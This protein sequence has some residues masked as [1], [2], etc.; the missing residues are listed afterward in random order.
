MYSRSLVFAQFSLIGLMVVYSQGIFSSWIGMTM[1]LAGALIGLWAIRHNRGDNFNIRPDLK[2]GCELIT[3]G[4][5]RFVRHPMY[6]SVMLMTLALAVATPI[7]LE[8]SSFLLLTLVLALKAVRE[9]RL[10]CEGS[11]AY[12]VYMRKTKRFIPFIY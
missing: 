12:K 1:L 10:W 9:E 3:T 8:W 7:Y 6:T 2:E 5:Y 11:E 4:P